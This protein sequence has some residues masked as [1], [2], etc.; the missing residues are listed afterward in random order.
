MKSVSENQ[1]SSYHHSY[2]TTTNQVATTTNS[3]NNYVQPS[4]IYMN[5][6]TTN[7]PKQPFANPYGPHDINS[8]E[9]I[10]FGQGHF[11]TATRKSKKK[12]NTS[13]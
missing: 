7:Q 5:T 11:T 4:S 6:F 8:S 2:T 13:I 9:L 3:L 10:N 1:F 12:K